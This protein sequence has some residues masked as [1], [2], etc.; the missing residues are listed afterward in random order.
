FRYYPESERL[1]A[2]VPDTPPIATAQEL[3]R[4][5]LAAGG[6]DNVTVAVL[7]WP[8]PGPAGAPEQQQETEQES[9]EQ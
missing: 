8:P 2:V 1:A 9:Q 3:V 5:A 7:T 4:L 6:A